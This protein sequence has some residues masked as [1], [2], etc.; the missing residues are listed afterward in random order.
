[1]PRSRPRRLAGSGA[2]RTVVSRRARSR[3]RGLGVCGATARSEVEVHAPPRD[4]FQ[5]GRG[6]LLTDFAGC[7]LLVQLSAAKFIQTARI[8]GG[9][10]NAEVLALGRGRERIGRDYV[11]WFFW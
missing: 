4:G 9:N 11:H 5:S 6:K 1:M 7:G 8:L 10:E 2:P 3:P